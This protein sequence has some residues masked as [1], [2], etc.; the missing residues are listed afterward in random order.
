MQD[1]NTHALIQ[2]IKDHKEQILI[3]AVV[4]LVVVAALL[5]PRIQ[6]SFRQS[7][8]TDTE[9]ITEESA[10]P[11]GCKPGY[12]FSE[13]TG[14]PCPIAKSTSIKQTAPASAG[15]DAALASYKGKVLAFGPACSVV[16]NDLSVSAGTRIMVANSSSESQTI[17]LGDR[18]VTL[19]PYHYFTQSVKT[20]GEV[21]TT[22]NGAPA[23]TV[24]V[25]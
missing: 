25:K 17:A 6:K 1:N 22:C 14:K 18:S 4:L 3:V 5:A 24:T 12:N 7:V 16:P 13:T 11:E 20:A 8:K 21:S 23:A 9:T 15:Y 10:T 2:K 19:Q